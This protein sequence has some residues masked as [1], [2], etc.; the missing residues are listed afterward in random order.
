MATIS[1]AVATTIT[2]KRITI[3]ITTITKAEGRRAA[4]LVYS[5]HK[6]FRHTGQTVS[7]EAGV[8]STDIANNSSGNVIAQDAYHSD[9]AAYSEQGRALYRNHRSSWQTTAA[10]IEILD[11]NDP[12]ASTPSV[13][14][15]PPLASL[16]LTRQLSKDAIAEAA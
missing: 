12:R 11:A 3:A 5:M 15:L 6:E 13:H 14:T 2:N 8:N 9:S 7:S 4:T 1:V 10:V 16:S